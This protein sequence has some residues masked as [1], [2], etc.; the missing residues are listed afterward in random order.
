LLAPS[1]KNLAKPLHE[2]DV[3]TNWFANDALEKLKSV[4]KTLS[5]TRLDGL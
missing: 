5:K 3:T 1:A 2:A 4:I